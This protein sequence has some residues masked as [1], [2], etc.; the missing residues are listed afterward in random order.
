MQ[1]LC[2][3]SA[4]YGLPA[5]PNLIIVTTEGNTS[6]SALVKKDS[7]RRQFVAGENLVRRSSKTSTGLAAGHHYTELH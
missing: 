6:T 5:S 1:L 3:L 7:Q 4:A 2:H